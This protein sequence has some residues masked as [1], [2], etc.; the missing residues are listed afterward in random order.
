M[1]NENIE[2][3]KAVKSSLRSI[4]KNPEV[5]LVKIQEAVVR[6][7][8]ILIHTLQFLKLFILD[9]YE[10]HRTLPEINKC[11]IEN[12]MK[13]VSVPKH[14]GRKLKEETFELKT[15]LSKFYHEHYV[16]LDSDSEILTYINLKEILKYTSQEVITMFENNIKLHFTEYVGRYVNTMWK[17]K[18]LIKK[19]RK[20][21][22]TKEE[23]NKRIR[24]LCNELKKIKQDLLDI[25]CQAKYRSK[26]F[27]HD[28]IDEQVMII[29]PSKEF[30]QENVY[31]DLKCHPLDYL[32]CMIYMMKEVEKEG[33]KIYNV[34]PMRTNIVPKYVRLDTETIITLLVT[35]EEKDSLGMKSE[36]LTKIKKN[37]NGIWD[38]FFR[39]E[40]K[41]FNKNGYTFHHMIVTDGVGVSILFHR[42]NLLK[43]KI[44]K[45]KKIIKEEKYIDEL[46]D[47]S[48]VK[49][50]KLVGIDPGMED[51]IYCVDGVSKKSK[52]F[53]YSR[54][55]R[56]EESKLKKYNR[57]I[58]SKKQESEVKI[59]EYETELSMYNRKTLDVSEFKEYIQKK[60]SVNHLLYN[61]YENKIFR[62]LKFS[63]YIN[64]T[65]SEQLMMKK[66]KKI[67]G[68]PEETVI[69]FGDWE[70]K[71]HMKYKEPTKGKGMRELFRKNGY[72]VFLV[73]EFRT[74][75]RC[76]KCHGGECE[77]FMLRPKRVDG[78]LQLVHGL[79][80]CKNVNCS[81]LWNRDRNGASNIYLCGFNAIN[82]FGRPKFL[83]RK[84]NNWV[85]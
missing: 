82:G 56:N 38:F 80:R 51:L 84:N 41:E 10:T 55:Q 39:T 78:S 33:E 62:K 73:N 4:L 32:P 12:I 21:A 64:R 45:T 49:D 54:F 76:S 8:K 28:W 83:R 85:T 17:K 15:K 53:R 70:Q 1:E 63:A 57:L 81:C 29:L 26:N 2:S 58:L 68:K 18:F 13:T 43:S 27:Y 47:Y 36:L 72:E 65:K 42:E 75:C 46:Q 20:M 5:N 30:E 11:L 44:P 7:N 9:H 40:K 22:K 37:Q 31:Y 77:K 71:H 35:K 52:H 60:N 14:L 3:C 6:V 25:G 19:I 48:T 59:I 79:L 50:K 23:R 74:S 67:F 61:F 66:F 34:F 24:N 69:C 16:E